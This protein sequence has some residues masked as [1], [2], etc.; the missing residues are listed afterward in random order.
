MRNRRQTPKNSEVSSNKIH[1]V[2]SSMQLPAGIVGYNTH[3][4]FNGNREV[5]IDGCKGL[6]DYDEN[7]IRVNMGKMITAF[8]GRGLTIKCLTS[9]SLVIEGFITSIEFIT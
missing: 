2:V 6:L 7:I 9:D 1:K 4:E 3:F 8:Y 5:I